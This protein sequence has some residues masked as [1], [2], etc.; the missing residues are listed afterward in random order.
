MPIV[1]A[2]QELG[3]IAEPRVSFFLVCFL[4]LLFWFFG[5]VLFCFYCL[6]LLVL[7]HITYTL[8]FLSTFVHRVCVYV[9]VCV[10]VRERERE[11]ERGTERDR[12]RET[13]TDRQRQRAS[14]C[15]Q[16]TT[17]YYCCY[18]FVWEGGFCLFACFVFWVRV[19]LCGHGWLGTHNGDQE[20][21]KPEIHLPLECWN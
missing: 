4:L 1:P 20:G 17:Y 21:L 2:T 7:K 10:C 18:C 16:V 14:A 9:C 11:R 19:S 13:E 8:K 6:L 15:T 5:F 3:K 12:D